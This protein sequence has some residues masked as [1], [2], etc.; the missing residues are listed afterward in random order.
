[1]TSAPLVMTL[2]SSETPH[3][4]RPWAISEIDQLTF[5]LSSRL[6]ASFRRSSP[7]S[8]CLPTCKPTTRFRRH[9]TMEICNEQLDRLDQTLPRDEKPARVQL[10]NPVYLGHRRPGRAPNSTHDWCGTTR[11]VNEGRRL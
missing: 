1:M 5:S 4:R 11:P 2:C 10:A 7:R 6:R 9:Q 8:R 3:L